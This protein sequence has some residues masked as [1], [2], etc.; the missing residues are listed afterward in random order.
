M[1]QIALKPLYHRGKDCIGIYFAKNNELQ[2]IVQKKAGA[3]W[4]RT[5]TCWYVEMNEVNYKKVSASFAG[6]AKIDVEALKEFLLEKKGNIETAH[7][8][9]ALPK[10]SPKEL[11]IFQRLATLKPAGTQSEKQTPV[12]CTENIKALQRYRQ[13]L[14]LKSY[15]PSTIRT[16]TNEFVQFLNLIKDVPAE[17]LTVQR[18]KD[19][20]QYC[21][22]VLRLSENTL[23]SRINALKF[24]YEQ[25]Y[26]VGLKKY[27]HVL[28]C[29]R[30]VK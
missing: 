11:P 14:T 25:V 3:T 9:E 13:Q 2:R 18:L 28:L 21:H 26:P 29:L 12:T 6:K 15:S 8:H 27:Q 23:H 7:Q 19:Y 4:T 1:E 30:L 16:Y 10:E 24:Y 20:L 5:H 17:T 22:T